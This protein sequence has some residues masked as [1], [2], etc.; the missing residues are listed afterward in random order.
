M[1][2]KH[3]LRAAE[4]FRKAGRAYHEAG[5]LEAAFV[6]SAKAATIILEKLPSHKEY[7]SL[8]TSTQRHNLGLVSPQYIS[9][10]LPFFPFFFISRCNGWAQF[11]CVMH[12]WVSH[13][14]TSITQV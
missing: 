6:E 5:D 3:W 14:F 12:I 10:R 7:F 4:K 13:V 9:S 1:G 2:I 11:S 8:L